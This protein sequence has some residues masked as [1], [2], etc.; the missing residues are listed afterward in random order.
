[1]NDVQVVA[2]VREGKADAFG[3]IVERYQLPIV[4]YVYRI[5]GDYE[6]AKDL[7]Q[8]TF[9]MAYKGILKTDSNLSFKAW[10][11][12]IATNNARQYNRRRRLLS[13][14]P[15]SKVAERSPIFQAPPGQIEDKLIIKQVL[16]KISHGQR[17]CLILHFIEGFK[18]SEIADILGIT[19]YAV[20]KRVARGSKQFQILYGGG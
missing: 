8:D 19:K 20:S 2:Q 4:R 17:I 7:A 16:S 14:I 12:R 11:Y 1:M 6:V 9:V 5:T 10:L 3:K 13:F 15:F 18:Y